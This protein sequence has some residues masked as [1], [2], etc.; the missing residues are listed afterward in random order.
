MSTLDE[1]LFKT[2]EED[3]LLSHLHY[4]GLYETLCFKFSNDNEWWFIK[5]NTLIYSEWNDTGECDFMIDYWA[6]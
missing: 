3:A 6:D 5:D 4:V 2:E 1:I